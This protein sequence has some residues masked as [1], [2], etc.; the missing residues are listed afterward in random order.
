MLPLV[1]I[2]L[3]AFPLQLI[4]LVAKAI[5]AVLIPAAMVA[6]VVMTLSMLPFVRPFDDG[7]EDVDAV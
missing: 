6:V 3:L 4:E 2:I 7:D 5:G 1:V